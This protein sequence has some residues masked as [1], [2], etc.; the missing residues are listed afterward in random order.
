M[1]EVP[2]EVLLSDMASVYQQRALETMD[3]T[4]LA[5][6]KRYRL[7]AEEITNLRR[8][9]QAAE[10]CYK[11]VYDRSQALMPDY[12]G[13]ALTQKECFRIGRNAGLEEAAVVADSH[14]KASHLGKVGEA[15]RKLKEQP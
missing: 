12:K 4:D 14:T 2:I 8:R 9:L 13:L 5:H 7:A 15:I 3:K 1:T 11:D 6:A 10:F